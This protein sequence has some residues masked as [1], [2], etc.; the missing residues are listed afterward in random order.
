MVFRGNNFERTD[1]VATGGTIKSAE[2]FNAEGDK[3]YTFDGIT[4]D[5]EEVYKA[6]TLDRDPL[7]I[8]HGL[9]D[10]SDT[11]SG[12]KRADSVWGFGGDDT[13]NGKGDYGSMATAAMTR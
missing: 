2:F 4:A 10:G 3:I 5:A 12:T 9:M 11:V 7:R 1:S 6:F 13:I 8:I